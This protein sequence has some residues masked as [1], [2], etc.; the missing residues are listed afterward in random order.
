VRGFGYSPVQD[1]CWTCDFDSAPLTKFS[2]NGA[3]G[4]QVRPA[5]QMASAY[6]AACDARQHCFWITQAGAAGASPTLKMDYSYNVVDS[7]NAD[8]WNQGGGCEVWR[9]TFLLQLNQSTPDEVYCMRFTLSPLLNHDVGV[10]AI[11]SPPATINP[12]TIAPK[13]RLVN[14]GENSESDIPVTCWIDSAGVRLYSATET[15]PGPLGPGFGADVAFTPN[16]NSGPVGAQYSLT[17][18]TALS[19][20]ENEH[21]DTLTGTTEVVGAL[22]SDTVHVRPAGAVV[23]TIDGSI[24]AGEWSA[25]NA[26]DVSDLAGRGGTPQPA[27]SCVAY[28]LYDTSFVYLALDCP[29]RTARVALDQFGPYIDEDGSASW[30][31]D[32]SEGGYTI[33]Y[34]DTGDQVLYFAMLDTLGNWYEAGPVSDATSASSLAS[35]HLQF[36]AELPI[37]ADKYQLAINSGDTAGCFLYAALDG[38][39]DYVGWW[40]QSVTV[41]QWPNPRY[42]GTLAFD[43]LPQGIKDLSLR[44]GFALRQTG[45]TLVRDQAEIRYYVGTATEIRLAVYDA[46]GALVRNLVRG[47]VDPGER[48]AVWDRTD[49]SG[50]R[51]AAGTYFYRLTADGRSVSG[52]AIVLE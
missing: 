46:A 37:G 44:P 35:G 12:G 3:N 43:P 24:D 13:A 19:G 29:N 34:G 8:G 45:P 27:G 36:E 30:A 18:F 39:S 40:P 6:G 21:D 11:L 2:I 22:F 52:K 4:H 10:S 33:E 15:L 47:R 23:P 38:L 7:F 1:S 32:S 16:W 42:Y 26:Y 50:R 28:F 49:C 14:Y 9:D 48:T 31:T 51:V 25:A 20:D 17:L 5:S 41:S